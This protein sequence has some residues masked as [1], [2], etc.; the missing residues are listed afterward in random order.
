[1]QIFMTGATGFIGS[2]LVRELSARGHRVRAL[3]RPTSFVEGLDQYAELLRGDLSRKDLLAEGS[4]GVDVVLHL[5]GVLSETRSGEFERVHVR[6]TKNLL[7]ATLRGAGGLQRF[8]YVSSMAAVGPSRDGHPVRETDPPHP[9]S[10]Y[11]LSKLQAEQEVWTYRTRFAVTVVRP[12]VVYGP[13][14]R[15][16]LTFFRMAQRGTLWLVQGPANLFSLCHVT[17]LV[18]GIADAVESPSAEN[19]TLQF[20]NDARLTLGELGRQLGAVFGTEPRI[21]RIPNPLLGAAALGANTWMR[22]TGRQGLYNLDKLR[23]IRGG[24]WLVA[25]GLARSL[26]GWRPEISLAQG[27]RETAE[28][29]CEHGWL[30]DGP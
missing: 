2:H 4:A 25:N 21:R 16:G 30:R 1:M 18:R 17:D 24:T 8:F 28:W 22:L 6:G 14:D 5:A 9:V 20:A 12:S 13:G 11:G 15:A 3:V 26:I 27:I 7:R 19:C 23:E 10:R 29:Y